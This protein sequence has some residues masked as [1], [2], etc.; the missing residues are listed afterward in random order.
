MTSS[1]RSPASGR[2]SSGA[3]RRRTAAAP[4]R[5]AGRGVEPALAQVV[6]RAP[7]LHGQRALEHPLRAH[8]AREEQRRR[9]PRAPLASRCQGQRRLAA[10]DVAAEDDQVLP[11]EPAA[12]H[13][14]ERGKAARHGVGRRCRPVRPRRSA[15]PAPRARSPASAAS[16]AARPGPPRARRAPPAPAPRRPRRRRPRARVPRAGSAPAPRSRGGASLSWLIAGD[17]RAPERRGQGEAREPVLQRLQPAA[18]GPLGRG[19]VAQQVL[20]HP[21]GEPE[22]EDPLAPRPARRSA[23]ERRAARSRPGSQPLTPAS[24][25]RVAKTMSGW[26]SRMHR[27]CPSGHASLAVAAAGAALEVRARPRSRGRCTGKKPNCLHRRPEQRHHRSADA[28]GHVHDPGIA[29]R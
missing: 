10:A 12:Q 25:V 27:W 1:K 24:G 14:V 4:D 3:S 7:P 22:R 16:L 28:G 20:R 13:A 11:A 21:H 29:A 5:R 18:V 9:R 26:I 8:L 17:Q 2:S 6:D 23:A 15:R 19:R